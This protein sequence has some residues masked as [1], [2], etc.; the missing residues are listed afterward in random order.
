MEVA[1]FYPHASPRIGDLVVMTVSQILETHIECHLLEFQNQKAIL[2]WIEVSH[3]RI[4]NPKRALKYNTKYVCS[5]TLVDVSGATLSLRNVTAS[6][7]QDHLK[8][9]ESSRKVMTIIH[10]LSELMDTVQ[11]YAVLY[12]SIVKA[13]YD[14][15]EMEVILFSHPYEALTDYRLKQTDIFT[16]CSIL[17]SDPIRH[18][19]DTLLT[20]HIQSDPITLKTLVDIQCYNQLGVNGIKTILAAAIDPHCQ[21]TLVTSPT[22]SVTIT[23]TTLE[24]AQVRMNC[25]LSEMKSTAQSLPT[26]SSCCIVQL[27]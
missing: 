22:Y 18:H 1:H 4:K 27:H 17:L 26:G 24:D 25:V 9:Y 20:H 12:D 7:S 13:L 14:G 19:L 6:E 10:R 11:T 16:P 8:Y 5:V 21:V 23:D 15:V 2:P 3:K